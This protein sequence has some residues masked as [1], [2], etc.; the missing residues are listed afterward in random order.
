[1][2][3]IKCKKEIKELIDKEGNLKAIKISLFKAICINCLGLEIWKWEIKLRTRNMV[4]E[5]YFMSEKQ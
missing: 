5:W 3:C 4:Q 2:N 1:M